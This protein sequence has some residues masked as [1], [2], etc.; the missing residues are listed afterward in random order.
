MSRRSRVLRTSADTHDFRA[1]DVTRCTSGAVPAG[2]VA[3]VTGSLDVHAA[4]VAARRIDAIGKHF[5]AN[6]FTTISIGWYCTSNLWVQ[7]G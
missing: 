2:L 1:S 5:M 7:I 3:G 6:P 4:N